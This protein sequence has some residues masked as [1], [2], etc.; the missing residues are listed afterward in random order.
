[1]ERKSFLGITIGAT[2]GLVLIFLAYLYFFKETQTA[3]SIRNSIGNFLP[4]GGNS[5]NSNN[6]GATSDDAQNNPDEPSNSV[7]I[8]PK[9][10]KI[11]AFP[12][13]GYFGF[14]RAT[15]TRNL[16]G[17]ST[18]VKISTTTEAIVRYMEKSTG[19]VYE[20]SEHTLDTVRLSNTTLGIFDNATFSNSQS[21]VARRFNDE[22]SLMEVYIGS[23]IKIGTTTDFKTTGTFFPRNPESLAVKGNLIFSFYK[24]P[25]SSEGFLTQTSPIKETKVFSSSLSGW[26]TEWVNKDLLLLTTK[27][28]SAYDGYVYTYNPSTKKQTGIFGPK[29]GLTAKVNNTVTGGVYSESFD[30]KLNFFIAN[31]TKGTFFQTSSATLPEKCVFSSKNVMI[32][33]CAVPRPLPPGSYPEDWYK[34]KVQFTDALV[35]FDIE[36]NIELPIVNFEQEGGESIDA[37]NLSFSEKE[38]FVYFQNK[39][40]GYVWSFDLR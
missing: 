1:M 36:K 34:G 27:P 20:A 18:V 15:T 9:L 7:V 28:N 4:L 14:D 39:R 26:N 5:S 33:Y 25:L 22:S 30:D 10:R 31:I 29:P 23:I 3:T 40:D 16:V 13:A 24:Y 37:V 35:R 17:T 11:S 38:T 19:H 8:I 32:V 12:V 6:G 21:F 2:I